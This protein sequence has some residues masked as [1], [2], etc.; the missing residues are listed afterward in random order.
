MK[1]YAGRINPAG[2]FEQASKIEI[3]DGKRKCEN[4]LACAGFTSKGS[5]KT[6][7]RDMQMYIDNFELD[8]IKCDK[9]KN[10]FIE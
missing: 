5:Y 10:E 3:N 4:D 2:K 1:F 7:K 9:S 8:R 6:L